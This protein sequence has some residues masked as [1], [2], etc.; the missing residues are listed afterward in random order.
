M[1]FWADDAVREMEDKAHQ[2][3]LA[4]PIYK[5]RTWKSKVQGD[6]KGEMKCVA[7]DTMVQTNVGEMKA[8]VV[9]T[10]NDMGNI[11]VV[12][13]DYYAQGIGKIKMHTEIFRVL[14]KG[15][16]D[17]KV[18]EEILVLSEYHLPESFKNRKK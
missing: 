13:N 1:F 8:F 17:I 7:V 9:Q 16:P 10:V 3:G 14:G 15:M 4:L 6:E 18:Q 2:R 5:G 12:Q 11:K